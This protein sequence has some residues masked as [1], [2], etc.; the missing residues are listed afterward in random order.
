MPKKILIIED[1][2]VARELM[3]TALLKSGYQIT[4]SEN[5]VDGYE[6]AL[7]L[8]PNLIVTGICMPNA[9]G[10]HVVRLIRNAPTLENTPILITTAFGDGSATFSLHL[11]A[12]AFEP[13]PLD[14]RTFLNTVERLLGDRETQKA[15]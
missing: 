2:G 1:D 5:G 14:P 13:K 15:A 3:R 12:N 8:K 4:L 6:T 10:I 7:F 9:D 11:G